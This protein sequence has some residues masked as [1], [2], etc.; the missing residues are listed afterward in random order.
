MTSGEQQANVSVVIPAYG[1]A[2]WVA[3][4]VRSAIAQP[5]A[6]EIIIVD[7]G[8]PDAS[9]PR[10]KE[11]GEGDPRVRCIRNDRVRGVCGARNAGLAVTTAPWVVF[12]DGDDALEPGALRALLA[13]AER[14]ARGA[15]KVQP[16]GVF[17]S[18]THVDEAGNQVDSSWLA[19]R[20]NALRCHRERPLTIE[21]LPLRTFNPPPG[22]QLLRVDALRS[23]GG[24]D[25]HRSEPGQSEDYEVVVRVASKG[26]IALTDAVVLRY[27]QRNA[28]RSQRSGNNRRRALTRLAAVRRAPRSKRASLARAQAHSYW[29]LGKVRLVRGLRDRSAALFGHGATDALLALVFEVAGPATVLLGPWKPRWAPV[30]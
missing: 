19:D 26:P 12:L 13:E 5:E 24:W 28:S 17:G 4:A 22:A 29:R 9:I 18:F 27:L 6:S 23:V 15:N 10:A 20:A 1:V 3:D 21:M 2:E 7:D 30:D 14:S 11:A 25:E 8:S 16:V